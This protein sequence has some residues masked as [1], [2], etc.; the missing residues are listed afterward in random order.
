[1]VSDSPHFSLSSLSP[2][3]AISLCS[4]GTTIRGVINSRRAKGGELARSDSDSHHFYPS[5]FIER[6][7]P[8]DVNA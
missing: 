2:F 8:T 4:V 7:K 1:M 6:A 5:P 3:E